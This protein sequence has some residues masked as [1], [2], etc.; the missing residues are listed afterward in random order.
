M[1]QSE[2]LLYMYTHACLHVIYECTCNHSMSI[3]VYTC[4]SSIARDDIVKAYKHL[5]VLLHPDKNSVPGSE[6][7]FKKLNSAKDDLLNNTH[8]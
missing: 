2:E 1:L 7:A 5:A 8:H 6:E 3:Q 4:T